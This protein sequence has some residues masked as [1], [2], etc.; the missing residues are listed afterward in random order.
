MNLAIINRSRTPA[1]E[2]KAAVVA[3]QTQLNRDVRPAWNLNVA[4]TQKLTSADAVIY[5]QDEAD[6]EGALG[7]HAQASSGLPYGFVFTDLAKELGEPWTVTLSHE[8]LELAGNPYV[9]DY[10]IGP[11]PEEDRTVFY[12]LELCDAVQDHKYKVGNVWVS[13]FVYPTY[14][15]PH[16]EPRPY[17][18]DHINQRHVGKF[19]ASLGVAPG[20]YVGFYDPELGEETTWFPHFDVRSRKRYELR[21][22]L[23]PKARR[24]AMYRSRRIGT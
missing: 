2:V 18:N 17:R 15:T 13:N 21:Q 24:G 16:E 5:I 3:V 12:W 7:Y 23:V 4:L 20:G 11:H 22:G 6:V 14:F 19:L 10:A 1:S 9:S 8:A